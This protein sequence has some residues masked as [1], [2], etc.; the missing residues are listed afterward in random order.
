M[1]A[2]SAKSNVISSLLNN[3][4]VLFNNEERLSNIDKS[5]FQKS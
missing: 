3:N 1:K 5:N 4:K 2:N